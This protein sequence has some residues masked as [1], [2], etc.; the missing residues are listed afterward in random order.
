[1][2]DRES[3][4]TE[5]PLLDIWVSV[6]IID[7]CQDLAEKQTDWPHSHQTEPKEQVLLWGGH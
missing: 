4:P 1:M 3:A 6:V 2:V 7:W 5:C